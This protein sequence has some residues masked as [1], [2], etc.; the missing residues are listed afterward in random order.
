MTRVGQARWSVSAIF[1]VHGIIVANW[2]TRIPA[3]E[4]R[5]G[6]SMGA[7]GGYLLCTAL[8]ALCGM[9]VAARLVGRFGSSRIV[10]VSTLL[11]CLWLPAPG[12]VNRAW[13]LA[14]AL[15]VFGWAAATMEVSMNTQAVLVERRLGRP[16]MTSFHALFSIGGMAG[17]AMG[18][19]AA[20]V[21]L[22]PAVHLALATLILLAPCVLSVRILVS[23]EAREPSAQRLHWTR[24]AG[25]LWALGVIAFCILIGE[26]AMADWTAVYLSGIHRVTPGLAAAGYAVFSVCMAIGRLG[27]D[28]LRARFDEVT[29]IRFGAGLASL[30]LGLGLA[31]GGLAGGLAGFACAGF[32]FS[33]IFPIL[34]MRSG[35]VPGISPQVGIAAVTAL[36]YSGFLAGPPIIGFAAQLSSLRVGLGLIP[37]LSAVAVLLSGRLPGGRRVKEPLLAANAPGLLH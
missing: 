9:P 4:Y 10:R 30:G 24:H 13:M 1:L 11:F 17:A 37:L 29:I 25:A 35:Q 34:T 7:L 8:G 14:P 5:F 28:R 18:G 6:L 32:G 23:D 21:G 33:S 26:G 20:S 19:F 36:G 12:L 16:V 22:T 2:L 15:F 31:V 3:V 27:G